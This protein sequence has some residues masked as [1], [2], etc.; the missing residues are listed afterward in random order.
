MGIQMK[1]LLVGAAMAAVACTTILAL[2]FSLANHQTLDRPYS[3]QY[4]VVFDAGSTHTALFLY[5]W[6]GNKENNTGI[7]SQKQSCDVDGAG[8]SSYVQNPLA[9]GESLKKCLDIAKA[10]IPEGERKTTPVYLGATAG[11][12]LLSLQNK[13]LADSILAEVTK[14]IQS[15]PFD[16]RG[17]R[18]LSGMEEGAFGWITINYLIE[19]FI[20]VNNGFPTLV[21]LGLSGYECRV[22]QT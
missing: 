1:A 18:I 4:G 13:S 15:Y 21:K 17:A 3:K 22:L 10:A 14:T 9:A 12:R 8:I 11:M 2:I 6:V 19:S 20:K 5:Q 7:V 16:F